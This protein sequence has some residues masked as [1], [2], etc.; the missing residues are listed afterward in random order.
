MLIELVGRGSMDSE[1]RIRAF[2]E[3]GPWAVVGASRDRSKF[4]NKVLRCYL[5]HRRSPLYP[6]NPNEGEI[7]RLAAY[8]GLAATPVTPR[9]VSIITPPPV[10][11]KVVED[12]IALGI[13]HLWMQPGAESS[14]AVERAE[15][16]GIS[17]IS[18][19]PC[20]LVTLGCRG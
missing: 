1:Q 4:G 10:T 19:G 13:A 5:Q 6:I 7:E 18:G 8:P 14:L 16:A 2:L 9:A 11:E 15:E 3:Q 12:A 20:L 17:V